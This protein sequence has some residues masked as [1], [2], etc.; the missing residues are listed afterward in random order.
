MAKQFKH[1]FTAE[2][3]KELDKTRLEAVHANAERLGATDLLSMCEAELSAR[4][5]PRTSR[6]TGSSHRGDVVV[7]YHFVCERDLGVTDAGKGQFWSR[8]WVVAE[9]NVKMSLAVGAYLALHEGR[10]QTSYRQGQIVGYRLAPRDLIA[11]RNMGIEFLVQSSDTPLAWVGDATGEKG[12]KWASNE[13][14][15]EK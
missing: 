8:S 3:L 14:E 9:D 2:R 15:E 11:K 13:V 7:G 10:A 4:K 5:P 6:S 1:N 12:Y